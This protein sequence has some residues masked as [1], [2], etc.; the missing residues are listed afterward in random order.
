MSDPI[1][2]ISIFSQNSQTCQDNSFVKR[3][4]AKK[5]LLPSLLV[6]KNMKNAT[7]TPKIDVKSHA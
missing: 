7:K 5:T 6:L 2:E 4:G 3:K 1:S